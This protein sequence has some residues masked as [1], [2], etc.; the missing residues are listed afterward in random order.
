ME[1]TVDVDDLCKKYNTRKDL[2]K[3]WIKRTGLREEI[4][5]F[6]R[7][8]DFTGKK[9]HGGQNKENIFLSYD[10][11]KQLEVHYS[12]MKRNIKNVQV[13]KSISLN[14]I[15]TIFTKRNRDFRL[16]I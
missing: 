3:R 15:Y 10:A 11:A 12:I 9:N 1:A 7:K 4:D 8:P 6:I 16:H 2:I 13:D 5:Y 14:I